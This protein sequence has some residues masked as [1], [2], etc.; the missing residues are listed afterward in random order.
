[1]I[2]PLATNGKHVAGKVGNVELLG[3]PRKLQWIQDES[4]LKIQLPVEK[5]GSHA[6]PFKID[7]L[8][9]R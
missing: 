9:L 1:M 4:G 8:D 3:Y 2:V 7:G 5:P 6:F